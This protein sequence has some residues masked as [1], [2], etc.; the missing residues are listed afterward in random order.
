MNEEPQTFDFLLG[1]LSGQVREL[2]HQVN[3]ISSKVDF[4]GSEA[5]KTSGLPQAVADLKGAVAALEASE[6]KRTGA[7]G[8]AQWLISS[9]LI[10]WAGL[11]A[12]AIWI[13]LGGHR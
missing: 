6:N 12:V 8:F 13:A 3:N 11:A 7:V 4:I 9:P 2:I 10:P 1:K 5:I